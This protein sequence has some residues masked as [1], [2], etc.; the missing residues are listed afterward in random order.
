MI[1]PE[2][3]LAGLAAILLT[4]SPVWAATAPAWAMTPAFKVAVTLSPRAA[5]RLAHPHDTILVSAEFYGEATPQGVRRH[6]ADEMNWIQFP[7][8]TKVE[9][10]AAGVAV[11]P[12][13][14]YDRSKL[15]YVQ[16]GKLQVLINVYSGR[17]SGPDNL[18][19]CGI[20]ED[21]IDVAA[22]A[23]IPI[24]CKLIGESRGRRPTGPTP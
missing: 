6:M 4:G 1:R 5:A 14:R 16:G 19:D 2:P 8:E 11:I 10:P 15:A 23:P 24:A 12:P 13:R 9:L 20:F 21:S 17:R 18:I 22:R 7:P 3:L